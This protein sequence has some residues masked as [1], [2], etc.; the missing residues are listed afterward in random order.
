MRRL[1]YNRMH[2]LVLHV[3]SAGRED[4]VTWLTLSAVTRCSTSLVHCVVL[5]DRSMPSNKMKAPRRGGPAMLP[6]AEQ[7]Q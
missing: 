4:P 7:R 5:P 6:L 3:L 2:I 1:N